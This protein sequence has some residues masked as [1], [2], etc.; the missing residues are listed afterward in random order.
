[1]YLFHYSNLRASDKR[2]CTPSIAGLRIQKTDFTS[3]SS[4]WNCHAAAFA[5]LP[6]SQTILPCLDHSVRKMHLSVYPL[7]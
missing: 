6:F 3:F 4:L 5:P 7:Q 1:M 2:C